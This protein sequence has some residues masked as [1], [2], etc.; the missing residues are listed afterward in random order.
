MIRQQ[1]LCCET[2]FRFIILNIPVLSKRLQVIIL[3]FST[4]IQSA[5]EDLEKHPYD[6]GKI[7]AV[8]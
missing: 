8:A 5:S 4:M 3:Y 2:A 7:K 6:G 1:P